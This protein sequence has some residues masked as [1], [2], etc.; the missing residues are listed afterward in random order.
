MKITDENH[1][2]INNNS[3]PKRITLSTGEKLVHR[4]IEFALRYHIPN[5]HKNA[6]AYGHAFY[7]FSLSQ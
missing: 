3:Y 4:K 5:K 2:A 7:V 6:E 1:S